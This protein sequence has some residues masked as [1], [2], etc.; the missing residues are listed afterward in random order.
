MGLSKEY[1]AFQDMD[2]SNPSEPIASE[3]ERQKMPRIIKGGHILT[4]PLT[5]ASMDTM[6]QE[7]EITPEDPD[8]HVIKNNGIVEAVE[9]RCTCGHAIR[10]GFDYDTSAAE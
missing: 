5:L 9:V 8:I 10:L 1:G 3:E 4:H 7:K 6:V 2:Y